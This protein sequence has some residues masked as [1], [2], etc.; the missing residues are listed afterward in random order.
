MQFTTGRAYRAASPRSASLRASAAAGSSTRAAPRTTART[1]PTARK[2]SGGVPAPTVARIDP[3]RRALAHHEA[4]HA[5]V[6]TVLGGTVT[7]AY[8]LPDDDPSSDGGRCYVTNLP[9]HAEAAYFYG[10]SFAEAYAAH[11]GPPTPAHV[12]RVVLANTRDHAALVAA[13]DPRP[14]DV[15]RIISTCWQSIDGLAKKLYTEGTIGQPDVDTAL[16]LPDAERDPEARAHAL[17]AIRA[18]SV[19][20]TFEVISR[21]SAW[22]L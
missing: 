19:P 9:P 4:G 14:S 16:G 22:K 7:K 11:G 5:V 10:G 2:Y 18:G 20:G 15:P 3:G 17:A 12:R 13:G 8:L 1:V 21:D 6:A